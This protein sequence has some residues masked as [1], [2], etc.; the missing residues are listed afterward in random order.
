MSSNQEW[1]IYLFS[2][3]IH[4]KMRG[5]WKMEGGIRGGRLWEEKKHKNEISRQRNVVSIETAI[6]KVFLRFVSNSSF[7]W[8]LNI[9]KLICCK[10]NEKS[11][12]RRKYLRKF[13]MGC[14]GGSMFM[15]LKNNITRKRINNSDEEKWNDSR[16]I[17]MK[18]LELSE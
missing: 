4:T 1:A 18:L 17:I 3:R 6:L 9:M 11:W 10:T 16:R 14:R 8:I 2:F 12:H 15:W 7:H 5:K 13:G